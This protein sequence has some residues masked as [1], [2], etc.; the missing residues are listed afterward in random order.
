MRWV[1]LKTSLLLSPTNLVGTTS[2]GTKKRE[3]I[4]SRSSAWKHFESSNMLMELI[5]QSVAIVIMII[6]RLHD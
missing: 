3:T 4:Q 6:W 5:K 2:Q 1:K